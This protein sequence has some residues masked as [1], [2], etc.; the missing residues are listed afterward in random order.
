ML[1]SSNC[2]AIISPLDHQYDLEIPV[3]QYHLFN[4]FIKS[5]SDYFAGDFRITK[6]TKKE[7]LWESNPGRITPLAKPAPEARRRGR[8]LTNR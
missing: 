1:I 5:V 2:C 6:Y 8:N 7:M 3:D 4:I